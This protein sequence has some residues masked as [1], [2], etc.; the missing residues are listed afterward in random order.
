MKPSLSMYKPRSRKSTLLEGLVNVRSSRFPFSP[1]ELKM[2]T[3]LTCA[4]GVI[5]WMTSCHQWIDE[6][7]QCGLIV[8][9]LWCFFTCSTIQTRCQRVLSIAISTGNVPRNCERPEVLMT[10][11]PN[12]ISNDWSLHN[13]V[14]QTCVIASACL[15]L[16]FQ[17]ANAFL[18]TSPLF[19]GPCYQLGNSLEQPHKAASWPVHRTVRY[20]WSVGKKNSAQAP[21]I[22]FDFFIFPNFNS[23][24]FP[25][26]EFGISNDPV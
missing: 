1:N 21:E 14:L 5:S 23:W 16:D 10:L 4:P 17:M 3:S 7:K 8:M 6:R 26:F 2:L 24:L 22:F 15:L 20:G 12:S 18:T 19:K 25:G 11:L 9:T 13:H